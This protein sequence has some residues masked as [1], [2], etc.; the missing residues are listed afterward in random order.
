MTYQPPDIAG[1]MGGP[2]LQ[3]L[4]E[5][6]AQMESIVEIGSW[7]GKSTHA[8]CSGC[9][10]IVIAVDHFQ[11]SPDERTAAHEPATRGD[12][13]QDFWKNVGHFKHLSLLKM[14]SVRA[15]SLFREKTIDMIFIDGCHL[16]EDFRADLQS[17]LPVCKKLI[18]G[19]DAGYESVKRGLTDLG[20]VFKVEGGIWSLD[21]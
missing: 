18:C 4:F 19:H 10:G 11:G 1:W 5:K 7:M 21:L 14:D 16:Y 8:L 2:E 3:W 12:I 13:S 15:A 20:L 17:W 6:A 9:P